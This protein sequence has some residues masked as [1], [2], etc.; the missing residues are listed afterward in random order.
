MVITHDG[1]VA[2]PTNAGRYE[3]NLDGISVIVSAPEGSFDREVFLKA[4]RVDDN[5]DVKRL[6]S[7]NLNIDMDSKETLTESEDKESE[8]T[9]ENI[10]NVENSATEEPFTDEGSSDSDVTEGEEYVDSTISLDIHFEDE[11]GSEVEPLK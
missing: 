1:T 11:S 5:E 9:E 8:N 6:L 2:T 4:S 3:V 10:D 7:K